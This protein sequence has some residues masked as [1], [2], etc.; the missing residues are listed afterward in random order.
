MGERD[1]D[2][3]DDEKGSLARIFSFSTISVPLA[4]QDQV[5]LALEERPPEEVTNDMW[6]S[7]LHASPMG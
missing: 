1:K 7:F 6:K 5:A 2:D 3:D 4:P